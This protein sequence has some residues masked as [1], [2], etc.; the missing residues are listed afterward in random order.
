MRAFPIA[1]LIALSMDSCLHSRACSPRHTVNFAALSDADR[2]EITREGVTKIATITDPVKVRRAA[3]FIQQRSDDW[4]EVLA[5]P[6]AATI[7][8]EFF[9]GNRWA[10][11][12]GVAHTYLVDGPTS[13]PTPSAEIDQFLKDM[14][15]NLPSPRG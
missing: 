15:V 10:G 6:Q 11:G 3:L 7:I 12:F 14:G 13:R 5:G 8:L 9:S 1:I 4:S 2:I